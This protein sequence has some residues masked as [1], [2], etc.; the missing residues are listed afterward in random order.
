MFL[1]VCSLGIISWFSGYL[2]RLF[3]L[4]GAE[5]LGS[6]KWNG[7]I[8]WGF[9]VSKYL[10][11][12]CGQNLLRIVFSTGL[13][14][15]GER[16]IFLVN[17]NWRGYVMSEYLCS[18]IWLCCHYCLVIYHNYLCY[19]DLFFLLNNSAVFPL[20]CNIIF[21]VNLIL[22]SESE[23]GKGELPRYRT[24]YWWGSIGVQGAAVCSYGSAAWATESY[25]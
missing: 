20:V 10:I 7:S 9:V 18:V 24:K 14:Y 25:A 13:W 19:N 2:I 11:L 22:F 6:K 23:V 1:W 15:W 8:I 4:F 16:F 5:I 3:E 17:L 21:V 12:G